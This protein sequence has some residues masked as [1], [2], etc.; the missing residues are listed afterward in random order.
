MVVS[1]GWSFVTNTQRSPLFVVVCVGWVWLVLRN[2]KGL[3]E[4]YD[5]IQNRD[6][7]N[8]CDHGTPGPGETCLPG[9]SQIYATY[10]LHQSLARAIGT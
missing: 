5:V 2:T 8:K 1:N 4:R 7:D 9:L 3:R 10:Q 6:F